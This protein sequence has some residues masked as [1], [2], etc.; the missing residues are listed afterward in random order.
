M[1]SS[2]GNRSNLPFR[3]TT[4]GNR[5]DQ[6]TMSGDL[7]QRQELILR[8]GPAMDNASGFGNDRGRSPR[9][10]QI[11]S[12]IP[13]LV[14]GTLQ[15]ALSGKSG[16]QSWCVLAFKVAFQMGRAVRRRDLTCLRRH[17]HVNCSR[18][19]KKKLDVSLFVIESMIHSKGHHTD[20]SR[21][22]D[23]A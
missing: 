3:R 1:E 20:H 4:R 12:R 11:D 6:S 7:P 9:W 15:T 16:S 13:A 10:R 21:K 22:T 8:S 17:A 2:I 14:I 5:M 18:I 19:S 23:R